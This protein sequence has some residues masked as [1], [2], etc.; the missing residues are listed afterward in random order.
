MRQIGWYREAGRRFLW[1][2]VIGGACF[3]GGIGFNRFYCNGE[4]TEIESE[5]APDSIIVEWTASRSGSS[6]PGFDFISG[7][8]SRLGANVTDTLL[9]D[10]LFRFTVP[11]CGDSLSG[12]RK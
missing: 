4:Q 10:S 9:A 1:Y 12:G 7:S 6:S 8:Q 5:I 3:I 11:D 2:L